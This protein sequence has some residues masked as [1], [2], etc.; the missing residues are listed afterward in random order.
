M[1]VK[2]KITELDKEDL[3]DYRKLHAA[4]ECGTMYNVRLTLDEA[5]DIEL[6]Y[7]G[8]QAYVIEKY[9]AGEDISEDQDWFIDEVTGEVYIWE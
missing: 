3:L 1:L 7:I 4:R 9:L 6:N 5:T 2:E 8:F